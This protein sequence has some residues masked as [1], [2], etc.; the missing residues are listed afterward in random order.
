MRIGPLLLAAALAVGPSCGRDKALEARVATLEERTNLL[1]KA[2]VNQDKDIEGLKGEVAEL[3]F[4]P[5]PNCVSATGSGVQF[6]GDYWVSN[7][8]LLQ[9]SQGATLRGVLINPTAISLSA[10]V[11]R[12]SPWGKDLGNSTRPAQLSILS[13]V[14]A[15]GSVGFSALL[16]NAEP[17]KVQ[18]LCFKL[19]DATYLYPR[20]AHRP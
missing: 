17:A 19:Q 2:V 14:R 16:P 10:V 20:P 6:I 3:S 15:G 18:G 11:F 8:E 1:A 5:E 9:H 4:K 7:L 12:V 13:G